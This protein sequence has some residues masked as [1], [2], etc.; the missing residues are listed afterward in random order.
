MSDEKIIQ[1]A[2]EALLGFTDD[3]MYDTL[4]QARAVLAVV[5][6]LLREQIAKKI[7]AHTGP[8]PDS[9]F[10]YRKAAEIARGDHH[11]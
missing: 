9:R 1:A 3:K 6:P 10:E 2:A 8:Y 7:E 5:E 4:D 11:G